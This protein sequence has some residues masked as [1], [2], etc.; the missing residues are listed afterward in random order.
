LVKLREQNSNL[1]EQVT[2]EEFAN[3]KLEMQAEELERQRNEMEE[4]IHVLLDI[5]ADKSRAIGSLEGQ[6]GQT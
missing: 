4:E 5:E 3:K 1:T 2:R 6:L